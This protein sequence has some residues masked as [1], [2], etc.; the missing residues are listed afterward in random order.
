MANNCVLDMTLTFNNEEDAI[1]FEQQMKDKKEIARQKH[2]GMYMGSDDRYFFDVCIDRFGDTVS[3]VGWVKWCLNRKDILDWMAYMNSI[4]EVRLMRA[5]YEES[6]CEIYGYYELDEDGQLSDI[7]VDPK[8][9]PEYIDEE[10]NENRDF[11]EE[12]E[13]KLHQEATV[14]LIYDYATE[15]IEN[16]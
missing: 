6:G 9:F 8:D 11:Y 13:Y 1:F 14:E 12:L 2:E 7:Y 10:G 15:E 4:A 16:D 5:Y 3:M